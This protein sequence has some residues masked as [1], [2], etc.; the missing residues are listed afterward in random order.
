[1]SG[2]LPKTGHK[3]INWKDCEG[4]YVVVVP[5]EG[6][7][8]RAGTY[9]NLETAIL[10]RNLVLAQIAA[11]TYKP[12]RNNKKGDEKIDS[13]RKKIIEA[14]NKNETVENICYKYATIPNYV[15]QVIRDESIGHASSQI[16][17]LLSQKWDKD[18][19]FN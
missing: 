13:K 5:F 7:R 15:N 14:L 3:Y 12:N 2:K 17:Y 9:K 8:A 6:T 16:R 11:G 1:M 10:R 19:K 4:R 18:F